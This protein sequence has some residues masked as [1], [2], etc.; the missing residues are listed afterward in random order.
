MKN[1]FYNDNLS[2]YQSLINRKETLLD[3]FICYQQIKAN[4]LGLADFNDEMNV[5]FTKILNKCIDNE[6]R[7]IQ[8]DFKNDVNNVLGGNNLSK[9][10]VLTASKNKGQ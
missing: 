1:K 9:R 3:A 4:E 5:A 7:G 8:Y 2:Y 10:L 6:E